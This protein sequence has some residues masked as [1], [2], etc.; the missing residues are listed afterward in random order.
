MTLDT[1]EPYFLTLDL[2]TGCV[3]EPTGDVPPNLP[4]FRMARTSGPDTTSYQ[5]EPEGV[6]ICTHWLATSPLYVLKEQEKF[7][8]AH[9]IADLSHVGALTANKSRIATLVRSKGHDGPG[10]PIFSSIIVA[11]PGDQIHVHLPSRE[12]RVDRL[13]EERTSEIVA[14]PEGKI[15]D[16]LCSSILEMLSGATKVAF[17]LSGG[18]DS[19]TLAA[20]GNRLLSSKPLLCFT[21]QTHGGDDLYYAEIAARALGADLHIVNI[22]TDKDALALHAAATTAACHPI[23]FSGNSIGFGAICQAAKQLGVDV[24]VDGTGGD[25]IFGGVYSLHG[26]YWA[27]AEGLDRT[28]TQFQQF[29][30]GLQKTE[31]SK[32]KIAEIL[33]EPNSRIDYGLHMR[34]E[35]TRGAM[36]RWR[37]HHIANGRAHDVRIVMPYLNETVASF[38]WNEPTAFFQGGGIRRHYDEYCKNMCLRKWRGGGRRRDCVGR[39]RRSSSRIEEQCLAICRIAD[40]VK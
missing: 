18:V 2:T 16:A 22:P 6:R 30:E 17:A 40:Y 5:I 8:F 14:L 12:L 7:F 25:P 19:T 33:R 32:R 9:S 28:G 15:E 35:I 29:L 36:A 26:S 20:L 3:H 4:R 1:A 34:R 31:R 13:P 24:I 37:S 23:P 21:A 10:D 27:R 38:I 11:H 39:L